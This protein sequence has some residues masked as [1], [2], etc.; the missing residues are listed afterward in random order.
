MRG[1]DRDDASD[2]DETYVPSEDRRNFPRVSRRKVSLGRRSTD[3]IPL[4]I[5]TKRAIVLTVVIVD[6]IYLAGDALLTGCFSI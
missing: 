1:W 2:E 6:A 4:D 5:P 3:D